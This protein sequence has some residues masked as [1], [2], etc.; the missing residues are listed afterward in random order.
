MSRFVF[1]PVLFRIF[2]A[3]ARRY[4][5]LEARGP[6]K[7][8]KTRKQQRDEGPINC[9]LEGRMSLEAWRENS[10]ALA[11]GRKSQVV[12]DLHVRQNLSVQNV[13]RT[14]HASVASVYMAKHRVARLVK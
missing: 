9:V 8:L 14:L 11:D 6:G 12:F 13:A 3:V 7:F 4:T 1:V 2:V 10:Q 5:G